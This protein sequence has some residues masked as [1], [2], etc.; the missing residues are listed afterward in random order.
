[1]FFLALT[2]QLLCAAYKCTCTYAYDLYREMNFAMYT[3]LYTP[4]CLCVFRMVLTWWRRLKGVTCSRSPV[5]MAVLWSG[6]LTWRVA[7]VRL[8]SHQVRL[9]TW[10]N[11]ITM[12][13]LFPQL[14]YHTLYYA[15]MLYHWFTF[16]GKKGDCT[17]SMK[18]SDF[19]SMVMGKLGPQKVSRYM[20]MYMYIKNSL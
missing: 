15:I 20:Y 11:F 18:D 16:V 13:V 4:V 12:Y 17:I 5:V 19:M 8:L 2:E 3:Y 7:V 14:R 6:W 10:L 9:H 1:M